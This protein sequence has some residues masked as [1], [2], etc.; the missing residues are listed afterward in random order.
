M[1]EEY[2]RE[3]DPVKRKELL[4]E[5]CPDEG[6]E[7]LQDQMR[8]LFDLRYRHNRKGGYDDCFLRSWLDLKL[9][10]GGPGSMMSKKRGTKQVRA[11]VHQLCLDRMG[12]F[13]D[14]ILYE[15]MCHLTMVYISSCLQDSKYIG[16]FW[17]LGKISDERQRSRVTV[18][19]DE[20]VQGLSR[21][22]GVEEDI[23]ILKR[24]IEDTEKRLLE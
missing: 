20:L 5:Y 8:I 23:R 3:P 9:A 19:L 18:D 17:G 16:A 6:A 11:A 21:Y 14:E 2:Y 13:A 1:F 12:E 10:A 22:P 15:E 4:D 24:A 7:A